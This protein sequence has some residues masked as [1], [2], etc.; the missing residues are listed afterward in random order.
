MNVATVFGYLH[1]GPATTAPPQQG[2]CCI[3]QLQ[4]TTAATPP[5]SNVWVGNT[6]LRGTSYSGYIYDNT[7]TPHQPTHVLIILFMIKHI[8]LN[9]L[10]LVIITEVGNVRERSIT[11]CIS[12]VFS[13]GY[14]Q[15]RITC[16][17]SSS[18][19]LGLMMSLH[20]MCMTPC[21]HAVTSCH[22]HIIVH[23]QS[24]VS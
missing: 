1:Q 22:T 7:S 14:S 24:P 9:T 4:H 12:I 17:S 15:S 21:H 5:N 11:C 10:L 13:S 23:F 18:T 16:E 19:H 6:G 2:C 20:V 3:S 8:I